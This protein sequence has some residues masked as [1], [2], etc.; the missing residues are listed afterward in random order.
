MQSTLSTAYDPIFAKHAGALPVAF[1]RA[2]GQ[3]ESDLN[4]RLMTGSAA[5]LLQVMPA[6]L[7]AYNA[8]YRT[9]YAPVDLLNPEINVPVAVRRL[10][11]IIEQYKKH[12]DKNLQSDFANPEFVKLLVS[13]WNSGPS[14]AGGVGKVARYLEGKGLRVTHDAV[15]ANAAAA[16]ATQWLQNQTRYNW[17]RS[18]ADLYF[19]QS[20]ARTKSVLKDAGFLTKAAIAVV[21]GLLAAK[22]LFR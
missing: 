1:L 9:S 10:N 3:R 19:A 22:Y 11:E 18:V 4:P 8:R 7:T 21:L 14:E 2:L 6:E 12:P 20:D 15:F 17:Q 5:G 16:G 13:G